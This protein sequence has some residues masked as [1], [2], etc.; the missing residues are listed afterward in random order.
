MGGH[1][2]AFDHGKDPGADHVVLD[3]DP[4]GFA[5]RDVSD[6]DPGGVEE[7]GD[8]G[9]RLAGP[10]WRGFARLPLPGQ[11]ISWIK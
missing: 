4:F 2:A 8:T 1:G 3:G 11:A 9:C 10:A 6:V 5:L 7:F